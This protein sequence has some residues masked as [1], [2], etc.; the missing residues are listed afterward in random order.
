MRYT[1]EE[2]KRA[3]EIMTAYEEDPYEIVVGTW[4]GAGKQIFYRDRMTG[5]LYYSTGGTKLDPKTA[6]GLKNF[7][8]IEVSTPGTSNPQ[9]YPQRVVTISVDDYDSDGASYT[10]TYPDGMSASLGNADERYNTLADII[11]DLRDEAEDAGTAQ[12]I[13][14]SSCQW[15]FN[16]PPA[17]GG[18]CGQPHK[19]RVRYHSY[20]MDGQAYNVC[21]LCGKHSTGWVPGHYSWCQ[22]DEAESRAG[23]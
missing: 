4:I 15:S 22:W 3:A 7:Q 20:R 19:H 11:D 9:V 16:S 12:G 21:T 8:V 6:T 23:A 18:L 10:I 17:P 14:C 2:L 1:Q 13:F 5:D